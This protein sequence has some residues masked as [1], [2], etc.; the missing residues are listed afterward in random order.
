VLGLADGVS[1]GSS[2]SWPKE[3]A[4]TGRLDIGQKGNPVTILIEDEVTGE[5]LELNHVE[6][7]FVVLEDQRKRSSGWLALAVGGVEKLSQVLGFMAKMTLSSVK[8]LTGRD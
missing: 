6:T 2:D 5:I 1:F 8:K 4:I 7:A 3:M